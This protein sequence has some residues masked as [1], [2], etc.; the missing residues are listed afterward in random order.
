MNSNHSGPSG[1]LDST[2][3][4]I[5]AIAALIVAITGLFIALSGN[6]GGGSNPA[7]NSQPVELTGS[8][9]CD[10]VGFRRCV[11]VVDAPLGSSCFCPGQ[12][13]GYTRK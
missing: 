3:G 10:S 11:L 9:C 13:Y 7:T 5:S 6:D 1:Y 12:G 2:A 8:H 4:I